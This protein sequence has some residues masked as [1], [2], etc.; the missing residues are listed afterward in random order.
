MNF[1][2][3]TCI[4]YEEPVSSIQKAINYPKKKKKEENKNKINEKKIFGFESVK[5]KKV[6]GVKAIRSKKPKGKKKK[7]KK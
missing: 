3:E 4:R 5:S 7:K 2:K 1:H 6:K